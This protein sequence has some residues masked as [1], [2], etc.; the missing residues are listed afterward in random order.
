MQK[1]LGPI[2]ALVTL[3][4]CVASGFSAL[5]DTDEDD[6]PFGAM[7]FATPYKSKWE[8]WRRVAADVLTELPRLNACHDKL[9]SCTP[10]ERRFVQIV[11]EAE[12][13]L[14]IGRIEVI[15]RRI[16]GAIQYTPDKTQWGVADRWTAPFATDGQG[17]FETGKGDCEDYAAAKFVALHLVGVPPANMRLVLVRDKVVHLV[18]A[19]LAVRHEKRWLILDNCHYE[20]YEDKVYN[21]FTPLAVVDSEGVGR[22]SRAFVEEKLGTPCA[23]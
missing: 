16:N 13:Q 8:K 2:G 11:I 23:G 12:A 10:A 19:I 7:Q 9:E 21:T 4:L 15:N 5:S 1:L 20:L 6:Q 14:G 22:L 3:S 17:S 18:H